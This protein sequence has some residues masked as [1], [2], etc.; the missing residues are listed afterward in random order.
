M[1][2]QRSIDFLYFNHKNNS[3]QWYAE[4]KDDYKKYLVKP[5]EELV[6]ALTPSMLKIDGRFITE[7]KVNY[8]ISR[9]YRDLRFSA[10]K[11]LYR[12]HMWLIF[13]RDKKLYNGVP[14]FY[15]ELT[16]YNASY[17][18][19][20]YSAD[21]S[22]M[23][24]FRDLIIKDSP[25][26]KEAFECYKSQTTFK[27]EGECYKTNKYPQYSSDIQDW[28][29]RRTVCFISK[30]NDTDFLFSPDLADTLAKEFTSIAPLYRMMIEAEERKTDAK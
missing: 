23:Q 9:L 3:R 7:P 20:Y 30:I 18:C 6:C 8:T 25:I 27:L 14:A 12:D 11:T 10:D 4:H 13:A 21:N 1:F 16:P 2:C 15:F 5:F 17:G 29:N 26:F 28:L 24:S 19:G 22:S